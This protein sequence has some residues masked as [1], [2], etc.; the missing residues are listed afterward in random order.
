MESIDQRKEGLRNVSWPCH[1]CQGGSN[2]NQTVYPAGPQIIPRHHANIA[3]SM[4]PV[5]E[6]RPRTEYIRSSYFAPALPPWNPYAY[7]PMM[8]VFTPSVISS[9]PFQ[10]KESGSHYKIPENPQK[11]PINSTTR[12]MED[13]R[14]NVYLKFNGLQ[15]GTVQGNTL[16]GKSPSP[17]QNEIIDANLA[18]YQIGKRRDSPETDFLPVTA[19]DFIDDN[20]SMSFDVEIKKIR[21]FWRASNYNYPHPFKKMHQSFYRNTNEREILETID[22][23]L[24]AINPNVDYEKKFFDSV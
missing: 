5:F 20:Q 10:N 13:L 1:I 23:S 22:L 17:G 9:L 18:Q 7:Y 2:P 21:N 16:T 3:P 4:Y 24:K 12:T 19:E 11:L 14:Q 6:W 15:S 8:P